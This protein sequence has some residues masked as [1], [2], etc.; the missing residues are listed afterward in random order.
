MAHGRE[1]SS[2]E[3]RPPRRLPVLSTKLHRPPVTDDIV[4]RDRLLAHLNQVSVNSAVLVSAPAGYGKST[5][6]S[7]LVEAR[8][9]ACAWVSLDST[10]SDLPEFVRYLTASI[11]QVLPGA[12]PATS[13]LLAA[14]SDVPVSVLQRTLLNELAWISAPVTLVL[15]DYH[16]IEVTSPAHLLVRE[17]LERP[18]GEVLLV[19]ATRR[20]PPL[21]I[22]ALRG[23]GRLVEIRLEDLRFSETEARAFLHGV[24]GIQIS[25]DALARLSEHAEG[26]A[27]GIR[28]A[29]LRISQADNPE[30]AAEGLT[31]SMVQS[32]EFLLEQVFAVAPEV[33]R[34]FLLSTS[35]VDRFCPELGA[36][37]ADE[38][39]VEEG[40]RILD[41]IRRQNLFLIPLDDE[42]EWWRYHHLFQ[43]LLQE[44]L[45]R[46]HG[47]ERVSQLHEIASAWFE[48]R[49]LIDEALRHALASG[50]TDR[51]VAIIIAHWVAEFEVDRWYNVQRWLDHLPAE[52]RT[53]SVE[54]SLAE[55][56]T[57]F[58]RHQWE[59]MP[60][61]LERIEVLGKSS[62]LSSMTVAHTQFFTAI[63]LYL[64]GEVEECL[65]RLT[66]RLPDEAAK[67]GFF[68]GNRQVYLGL[69]RSAVGQRGE[70]VQEL[71]QFRAENPRASVSLQV[72]SL[73]ATV[74]VHL[75]AGEL[76]SVPGACARM[77]SLTGEDDFVNL[78]AWGYS[79]QGYSQLHRMEL[80]AAIEMFAGATRYQYRFETKGH[81]DALAGLAMAHQFKGDFD[82]ADDVSQRLMEFALESNDA[83]A[84]AVS[85]SCR[86]RLDLLQGELAVVGDSIRSVPQ[87]AG[88]PELLVW[89][90]VPAITRARALAAAGSQEDLANARAA[91]KVLR[92][93]CLRFRFVCHQIDVEVLDALC[94]DR[95]GRPAEAVAVLADAVALAQPGG[96]VRPF[97]EAGPR[98]AG[99]LERLGR[100]DP[101]SEYLA[102]LRAA[103][104]LAEAAAISGASPSS[105][106]ATVESPAD[107]T[108]VELVEDLTQREM[109]VLE[110]LS[111]RLQNQEIAGQL[112]IST[113]TVN[114]HLK[115]IY[116]KLGVHNRRQAVRRAGEVGLLNVRRT[117]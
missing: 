24:C 5:L 115:H 101:G 55:L 35:I 33:S 39:G 64:S 49:G 65:L 29:A 36:A 43:S 93:T 18:S 105:P 59:A 21:Q 62:P 40:S 54:L 108:N 31:G 3:V 73:G 70:V 109:D 112:F 104:P 10:E 95:I 77:R 30:Q 48:S 87:D 4:E 34:R 91:L 89:I 84:L 9:G 17:F 106:S 94:L 44:R 114:D 92:E 38:S 58:C 76:A 60:P 111:R 82:A 81:I 50:N 71:E 12:C 110:L 116:E 6:V 19:L 1:S 45:S 80:D 75:L 107:V 32:K 22:A 99:L 15:D 27:V 16:R 67:L 57:S 69:A 90:E 53:S 66:H 74:F 11:E 56:W 8:D 26:W 61:I 86:V 37:L 2:T 7:Q 96:W 113:H 79:L 83:D 68:E 41:E 52:L 14:A 46:E 78:R 97:V 72:H 117:I 28:M 42:G 23:S 102:R 25:R 47:P 51:T 88:H 98:I 100:S 63:L 85:R 103:C 13:E 20:D